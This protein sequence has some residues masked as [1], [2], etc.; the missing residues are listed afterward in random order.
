MG[1]RLGFAGTPEFAATILR[2]L[3]AAGYR[4]ELVLTQPDRPA[5]RGRKL[6]ASPVKA[7]A[8]DEGL[9]VEQP[10]SLK[11]P[12]TVDQLGLAEL[13]ALIVAAYGLIL[14]QAVLDAPRGG[15]L[16][17]HASL[18]PR[19]RGAA[20][21]PWAIASGDAQS[22]VC[23]MQMEAG[24]DTGPVLASQ[25]TPI[26]SRETAVELHNRLAQ[27]GG[28]L[29]VHELAPILDGEREAVAQ[30]D[31][32]A[33]YAR[34]LSREDGRVEWQWPAEEIDRRIRA[35]NPYPGCV[36]TLGDESLKLWRSRLAADVEASGAKPGTVLSVDDAGM[37]VATGEGV[38]RVTEV[39]RPGRGRITPE[40]LSRQQA[41][42]GER[43]GDA[44]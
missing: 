20:P 35:F 13:D 18:L 21:I 44:L 25:A 30:D 22:G 27:L 2:H 37:N 15:C 32:L 41:L 34:K 28:D 40:A 29:L 16:N 36:A 33:T 3:L 24:L 31:A 12:E 9:R 4:P 19:W 1:L 7:L 39:Q 8:L 10:V 14:P 42:V 17:V 38:V 26:E 6:T 23:L 43:L 5:G 11:P